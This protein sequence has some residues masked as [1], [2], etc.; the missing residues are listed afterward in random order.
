[1]KNMFYQYAEFEASSKYLFDKDMAINIFYNNYNSHS[2][3]QRG[4]VEHELKYGNSIKGSADILKLGN[5]KLKKL[6][7]WDNKSETYIYMG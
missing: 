7:N 6:F 5:I 4:W 3:F 1:M 2:F